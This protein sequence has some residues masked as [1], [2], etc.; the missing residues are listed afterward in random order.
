MTLINIYFTFYFFVMLFFYA[1]FYSCRRNNERMKKKMLIKQPFASIAY[2]REYMRWLLSLRLLYI[3]CHDIS[4][5]DFSNKGQMLLPPQF[6]TNRFCLIKFGYIFFPESIKK[7]YQISVQIVRMHTILSVNKNWH[8][9][10]SFGMFWNLDHS[11][12]FLSG[13]FDSLFNAFD[14]YKSWCQSLYESTFDLLNV[15]W[16]WLQYLAQGKS[17]VHSF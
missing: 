16:I 17:H 8:V 5:H 3:T 15:S 11:F 4:N 14:M 9:P 2:D 12:V 13:V 6:E 10:F 1:C 7:I